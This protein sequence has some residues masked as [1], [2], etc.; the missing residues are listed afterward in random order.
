MCEKP[1]GDEQGKQERG[2]ISRFKLINYDMI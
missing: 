2:K 1:P